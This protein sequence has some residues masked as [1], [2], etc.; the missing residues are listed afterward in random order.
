MIHAYKHVMVLMGES[1]PRDA[2]ALLLHNDSKHS[3]VPIDAAARLMINALRGPG[4][5]AHRLPGILSSPTP[6]K[7]SCEEVLVKRLGGETA[8]LPE[9]V[10]GVHGTLARHFDAAIVTAFDGVAGAMGADDRPRP[11]VF[12]VIESDGDLALL[13]ADGYEP[14]VVEVLE[15]TEEAAATP[16]KDGPQRHRVSNPDAIVA[17]HPPAVP[18][19]LGLLPESDYARL[20]ETWLRIQVTRVRQ[21]RHQREHAKAT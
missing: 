14:F 19:Q 6:E 11:W 12:T 7:W 10:M 15:R 1:G 20:Q 18:H 16:P 17:M 5:V 3:F 21:L 4:V 2:F 9:L 13:R 8:S